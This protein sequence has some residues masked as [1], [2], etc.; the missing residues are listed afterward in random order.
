M[1]PAHQHLNSHQL[2]KGLVARGLPRHPIVVTIVED[3]EAAALEEVTNLL[4]QLLCRAGKLG[5]TGVASH[6]IGVSSTAEV[7]IGFDNG[8]SSSR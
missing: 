4:L 2:I 1:L 8:I 7:S 5:D 6:R 3:I